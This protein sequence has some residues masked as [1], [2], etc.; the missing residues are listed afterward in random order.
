M[1][2]TVVELEELRKRRKVRETIKR[3]VDHLISLK[4]AVEL[5]PWP[6]C[7]VVSAGMALYQEQVH[8]SHHGLFKLE[9]AYERGQSNPTGHPILSLKFMSIVR[10]RGL[11]DSTFE[12]IDPPKFAHLVFSKRPVAEATMP[13]NIANPS[14]L[15]FAYVSQWPEVSA[16]F[17]FLLYGACNALNKNGFVLENF[18]VPLPQA[19]DNTFKARFY[20]EEDVVD[21]MVD[22]EVMDMDARALRRS[23]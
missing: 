18:E 10:A 8:E 15:L 23:L 13:P 9:C 17:L 12:L 21:L 11:F 1:T 4:S 2:S 22:F 5:L 19:L 20:R 7:E 16:N 3:G 14:T 6:A